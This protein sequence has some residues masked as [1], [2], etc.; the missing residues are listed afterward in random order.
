MKNGVL[1]VLRGGSSDLDSG[2]LRASFRVR[3]VPEDRDWDN[4]FRIVVKRG[5]L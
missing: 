4:G 2:D 3:F 1:R 5:A